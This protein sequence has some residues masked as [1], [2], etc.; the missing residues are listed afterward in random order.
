M[1]RS[2][3]T[4]RVDDYDELTRRARA[5]PARGRHPLGGRRADRRRRPPV[6]RGDRRR[7]AP[8]PPARRRGGADRRLRPADH[9]RARQHRRARAARGV[10]RADPARRATRSAGGSGATSTTAPSSEL[11]SVV[12]S[13]QLAQKR[14]EQQPERARGLV[15]DALEHAQA[16]IDDLRELAAGIHPVGAH[17][18]RPA[19]RAG[20]AGRPLAACPSSSTPSSTS[21]CRCR[22]RRPRTSSSP[23]RSPT[24]ASTR[25]RRAPSVGVRVVGDQLEIEVLDDGVGGAD[26]SAGTGLRGLADRVARCRARCTSQPARARHAHA[27]PD[28]ARLADTAV[29]NPDDL[30]VRPGVE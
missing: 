2:G 7:R 19:R 16:A 28:L 8:L 30:S 23:R 3:R 17:R 11:V 18:P 15:D 27:R 14:W 1:R 20:D 13:L 22:S 5:A 24:S 21:G 26:A 9:R 10:A 4:V 6:G 29:W 12:I 25:A